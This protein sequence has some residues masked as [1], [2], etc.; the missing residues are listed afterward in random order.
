MVVGL[1]VSVTLVVLIWGLKKTEPF[2]EYSGRRGGGGG[3]GS[4][5]TLAT[6]NHL[7]RRHGRGRK[8]KR[9]DRGASM[10]MMMA[11]VALVTVVVLL[12]LL[13]GEWGIKGGI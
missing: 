9:G 8:P 7:G 13:V 4:T 6:G 11:L 10:T 3:P 5:T 12:L 1:V 2:G